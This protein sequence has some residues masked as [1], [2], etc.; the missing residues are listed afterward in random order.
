MADGWRM[1]S[2]RRVAIVGGGPAGLFAAA[3]FARRGDDVTVFEQG[4]SPGEAARDDRGFAFTL[5]AIGREALGPALTAATVAAGRQVRGRAV[6]Q[7]DGSTYTH[8][9]G[10]RPDDYYTAVG[11]ADFRGLLADAAATAGALLQFQTTVTAVDDRTGTVTVAGADGRVRQVRADLVVG[12]DGTRGRLRSAFAG[13]P[14]VCSHLTADP[15]QYITASLS[16][17]ATT[18][19]PADRLNFFC[20]TDGQGVAIA[21]PKAAGGFDLLVTRAFGGDAAQ[22]PLAD[23]RR[24]AAFLATCYPHLLAIQPDLARQLAGRRRGCFY[25]GGIS[26]WHIGRRVLVGDAGRTAPAW[27]GAGMNLALDDVR[28]LVRHVDSHGG[29]DVAAT[30]GLRAYEVD[31]LAV[32]PVVQGLIAEH[33]RLLTCRLGGVRFRLGQA[34]ARHRERLF[35]HRS[36]FQRVAFDAGGLRRAVDHAAAAAAAA[37]ALGAGE[38]LWPV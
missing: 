8:D 25:N 12:A 34:V 28:S 23:A 9:Y 33:G 38:I 31:R 24:A 6:H 7:P 29:G 1:S 4:P 17:E 37:A 5:N 36:L 15:T 27:L 21:V 2:E 3:E 30:D 22:A 11:R 14:G 19:L 32:T 20:P 10:T 16:A 18:G 13:H 35:G 26:R